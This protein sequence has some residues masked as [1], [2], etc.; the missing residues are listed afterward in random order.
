M[1]P[2]FRNLSKPFF[3]LKTTNPSISGGTEESP[4]SV[5]FLFPANAGPST[6]TTTPPETMDPSTTTPNR[7]ATIPPPPT[8]EGRISAPT[9]RAV[10]PPLT[11]IEPVGNGS[12]L[13]S[14]TCESTADPTTLSGN[15]IYLN[16]ILLF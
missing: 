10:T 2:P 14:F 8:S 6:G 7:A 13:F 16:N 1:S 5:P 15:Q 4:H 11:H 3:F 9:P 12:H